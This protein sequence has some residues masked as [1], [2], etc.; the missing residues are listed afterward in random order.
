MQF[1]MQSFMRPRMQARRMKIHAATAAYYRGDVHT[2]LASVQVQQSRARQAHDFFYTHMHACVHPHVHSDPHSRHSHHVR[3]CWLVACLIDGLSTIDGRTPSHIT[4]AAIMTT[5]TTI[6]RENI[7]MSN[8]VT[9]LYGH[10]QYPTSLLAF[11]VAE[12]RVGR[13]LRP[14]HG[15]RR[16]ASAMAPGHA[17]ICQW[18]VKALTHIHLRVCCWHCCCHTSCY[19]ALMLAQAAHRPTQMMRAAFFPRTCAAHQVLCAHSERAA[20][21]HN[22]GIYW[23]HAITPCTLESDATWHVAHGDLPNPCMQPWGTRKH[24]SSR[25]IIHAECTTSASG[26]HG[27]LE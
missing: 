5:S 7:H 26:Y 4:A 15:G 16:R 17:T 27:R 9:V 23:H 19:T 6:V 1:F 25:S 14:H 8:A 18:A 24:S 20:A 10:S 2:T 22:A 13:L 11:G 21:W 3:C 12:G